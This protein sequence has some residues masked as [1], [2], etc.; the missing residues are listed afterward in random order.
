MTWN[1]DIHDLF[2]DK[3]PK[4]IKIDFKM[5]DKAFSIQINDSKNSPHFPEGAMLAIEPVFD[6][7]D[8]VFVLV[9]M[10]QYETPFIRKV[11]IEAPNTY[12]QPLNPEIS[13]TPL[14][15]GQT[16]IG[17]IVQLKVNF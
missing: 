6:L 8:G 2:P 1:K 9:K 4:W 16:I 3:W 13:M 11:M 10:K 15:E 5:S 14:T 7:K 12:L 17:K